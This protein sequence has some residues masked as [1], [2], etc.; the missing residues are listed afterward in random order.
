MQP[1][2]QADILDRAQFLEVRPAHEREVLA[3]KAVRRVRVG[4]AF[5]FLFENRVTL[6]WQVHE[7]VRV[8][9]IDDRAAIQHELD[10]YNALLP[11]AGALS[12]TLL[13]E[14]DDPERRAEMLY[15][16]LGL[17]RCVR[18]EVAGCAPAPFVFD[19]Q[20]FNERRISS[21]QFIK[22]PLDEAQRQAFCDFTREARLTV[23]HPAYQESTLLAGAVRGAL[24]E[25]LLAP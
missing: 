9:R 25:D 4:D 12:A 5:T 20:Q 11:A 18:L 19:D 6:R 23:D 1:L 13:L 8:E 17:H 3:H 10:T 24:V 2:T 22:L 16:L 15:R 7:M 14:Y 21:V